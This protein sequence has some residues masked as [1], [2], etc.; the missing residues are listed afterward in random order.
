MKWLAIYDGGNT[1]RTWSL[2]KTPKVGTF[3]LHFFFCSLY[4]SFLRILT[5]N[6]AGYGF[7]W[8]FFLPFFPPKRRIFLTIT[9]FIFSS[10]PSFYKQLR[11]YLHSFTCSTEPYYFLT[12][13]ITKEEIN[14]KST[15]RSPNIYL[16]SIRWNSNYSPEIKWPSHIKGRVWGLKGQ[17]SSKWLPNS[18]SF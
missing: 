5:G 16:L 6:L 3:G 15:T 12:G 13:L 18:L 7:W 17:A 11:G 9:K 14:G 2:L 4:I 8:I 1:E 10:N